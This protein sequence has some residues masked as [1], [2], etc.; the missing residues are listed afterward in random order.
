MIYAQ[1]AGAFI[2]TATTVASM[3]LYSLTRTSTSSDLPFS[4]TT[5]IT[6]TA[7]T[8][9]SRTYTLGVGYYALVIGSGTGATPAV[10]FQSDYFECPTQYPNTF[11]D[12][13]GTFQACF[14]TGFTDSTLF[15]GTANIWQNTL[16]R[17]ILPNIQQR[18]VLEIRINFPAAIATNLPNSFY[19]QM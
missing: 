9:T 1:T 6:P 18:E 19:L 15:S 14:R 5:A 11:H 12:A 2:V 3:N 8:G 4:S 13:G 16:P 7:D 10:T 17:F